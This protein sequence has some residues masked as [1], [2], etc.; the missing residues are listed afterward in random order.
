MHFEITCRA[1]DHGPSLLMFRRF[2]QLARNDNWFTIEKTQAENALVT[3]QLG[4]S[5]SWKDRFF[6]VSEEIVPFAMS[7]RKLDESLN[8]RIPTESEVDGVL[9]GKLRSSTPRLRA[10]PE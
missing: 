10:I 8:K 7:W 1:L 4:F 9:L 6:L 3:S 2:F 5:A